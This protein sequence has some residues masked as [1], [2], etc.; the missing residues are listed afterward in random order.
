MTPRTATGSPSPTV[1]PASSALTP[2]GTAGLR[3]RGSL[4]ERLGAEDARDL[5]GVERFPLEEGPGQRVE[6]LDVLLDDLLGP[7]RALDDDALDLTVDRQRGVLAV[8]LGARHLA[9]EEDEI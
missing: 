2:R 5:L 8:V 3:R 9:T 4:G 6:L 7:P 1:T